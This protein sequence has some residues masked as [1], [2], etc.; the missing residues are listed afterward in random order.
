M[1]QTEKSQKETSKQV[2]YLINKSKNLRYS[3][4]VSSIRLLDAGEDLKNSTS[5][6]LNSEAQVKSKDTDLK[7]NKFVKESK[8]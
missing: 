5:L 8:S 7:L 3:S 4:N 1:F 2:R 6:D